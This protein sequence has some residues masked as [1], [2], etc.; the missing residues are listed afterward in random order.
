MHW[1]RVRRALLAVAPLFIA[2]GCASVPRAT[3][4]IP[5]EFRC[6]DLTS[7]DAPL[8]QLA[9]RLLFEAVTA[10]RCTWWPVISRAGKMIT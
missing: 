1:V 4:E 10:R 3:A 8:Q 9:D 2:F 7:L 5:G 6:F